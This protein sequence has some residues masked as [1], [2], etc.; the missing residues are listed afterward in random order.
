[1]VFKAARQNLQNKPKL[2]WAQSLK[3]K[4]K[5]ELSRVRRRTT[6]VRDRYS[7]MAEQRPDSSAL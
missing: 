3:R 6:K 7:H 1:V 4:A 2:L 5:K